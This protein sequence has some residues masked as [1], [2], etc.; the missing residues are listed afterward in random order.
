MKRE[1][2]ALA[3][4]PASLGCLKSD[5]DSVRDTQSAAPTPGFDQMN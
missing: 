5:S 3:I 4:G 2:L 1:V